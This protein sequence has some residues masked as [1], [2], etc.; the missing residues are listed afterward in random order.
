[1]ADTFCVDVRRKQKAFGFLRRVTLLSHATEAISVSR[2]QI[3]YFDLHSYLKAQGSEKH[4]ITAMDH[5]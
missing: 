1:M 2:H 3:S 5:G 4:I